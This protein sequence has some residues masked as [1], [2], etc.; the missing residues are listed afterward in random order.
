M[1][2]FWYFNGCFCF[3]RLRFYLHLLFCTDWQIIGLNNNEGNEKITKEN[4]L[5]HTHM[6]F[7]KVLKNAYRLPVVQEGKGKGER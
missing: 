3:I 5:Q 2:V 6:G 7:V 1:C 4:L